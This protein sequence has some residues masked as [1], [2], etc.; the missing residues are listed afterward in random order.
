MRS[1]VLSC[2]LLSIAMPAHAD[3]TTEARA[4]FQRYEQLAAT[5]D[6]AFADLYC[7]AALVRN[8]R[9]FPDGTERTLELPAAQYKD[10]VRAA[11]PVAR[12]RSDRSTF[13]SVAFTREGDAVRITASRYSLLKDYTSPISLKVAACDGGAWGILEEISESRP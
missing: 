4:L 10:L 11:M 6:P 8:T 3:G 2:L 7:D 9:R 1:L 13:S 12:Q 5:Y